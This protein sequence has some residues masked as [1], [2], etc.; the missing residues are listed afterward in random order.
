MNALKKYR[1]VLQ[2][3]AGC[4][5][6][7]LGISLF[8]RPANIFAGGIP[9]IAIIL[10][11]IFGHS[12]HRY[13]GVIMFCLQVLFLAIQLIFGGKSR[14]LKGMLVAFMVSS[15]VQVI[16]W[17]TLEVRLSENNL[18][19]AIAGSVLM[20][21]GIGI[22]LDAGFNFAGTVGVADLVSVKTGLPPGRV[23]MMIESGILIFGTVVIG[24]EQAI[25]SAIGIFLMGRAISAVT[26]GRHHF[27]YMIV[28]S[29]CIEALRDQFREVLDQEAVIINGR[30]TSD[31]R[32]DILLVLIRNDQLKTAR[33]LVLN[34]DPAA[35]ITTS[36][37]NPVTGIQ[38]RSGSPPLSREG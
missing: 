7:A 33:T 23:V 37:V 35:R 6:V 16:T 1:T 36:A 20:G 30:G 8:L 27:S 13:L 14:L 32:F 31:N 5:V 18:L 2:L 26:F 22:V 29:P 12:F 28:L 11:N 24:I 34:S 38:L 17:F 15:L 25:I 3:P 4:L 21:L 9:G 10:I 19:M